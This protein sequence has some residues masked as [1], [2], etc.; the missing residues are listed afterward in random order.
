VS[1]DIVE[2]TSVENVEKHIK[3]EISE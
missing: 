2:E 3:N 1:A